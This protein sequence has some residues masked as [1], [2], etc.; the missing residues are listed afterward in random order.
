M[1]LQK[2]DRKSK[3]TKAQESIWESQNSSGP[4]HRGPKN[5]V[6]PSLWMLRMCLMA[7]IKA[8]AKA[9]TFGV[10][11]SRQAGLGQN[12]GDWSLMWPTTVRQHMFKE[13]LSEGWVHVPSKWMIHNHV[14]FLFMNEKRNASLETSL[15]HPMGKGVEKRTHSRRR[16]EKTPVEPEGSQGFPGL[17]S[18]WIQCLNNIG[19]A[20][21]SLRYL[22]VSGTFFFL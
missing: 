3:K 20:F 7:L 22:I 11:F 21:S 9:K 2:W 4:H 8:K 17:C 12:L 18:H 14:L 5:V 1:V 6:C 13:W 15:S 19:L 10:L 16:E